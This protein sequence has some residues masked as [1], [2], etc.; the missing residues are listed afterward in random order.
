MTGIRL[1]IKAALTPSPRSA[2]DE[3]QSARSICREGLGECS[4]WM[5]TSSG[6]EASEW[7]G[8]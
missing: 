3:Q 4:P 5:K 6:V 7:G 2:C 1:E 8:K